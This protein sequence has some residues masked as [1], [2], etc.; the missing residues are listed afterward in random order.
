MRVPLIVFGAGVQ[1]GEELSHSVNLN[2]L[3]A[4]ILDF[5]GKSS[6]IPAGVDSKSFKD[7][8]TG[9]STTALRDYNYTETF[10]PNFDPTTSFGP[11]RGVQAVQEDPGLYATGTYKY[12]RSFGAASEAL[13]N[14]DSDPFE[15]NNLISNPPVNRL[16]DLEFIIDTTLG[17]DLESICDGKLPTG[18]SCTADS[19]CCSNLC[20]SATLKCI[21]PM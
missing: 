17:S 9:H 14:L 7:L 6:L 20:S 16:S 15:S 4:T 21:C 11:C 3:Y 10:F 12:V 19:D 1:E 18:D 8:L 13:Y 2:D 5:A